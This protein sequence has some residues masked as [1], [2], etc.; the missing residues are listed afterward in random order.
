MTADLSSPDRTDD[1]PPVERLAD[2]AEGLVDSPADVE[3]LRRHLDGCAECRETVDALAEVQALL[4]EVETPPMPAD[5]ADRLDAAL[6]RAAAEAAE[7]ADAARAA[8]SGD[9]RTAA[10]RPQ[11]APAAAHRSA[12]QAPAARPATGPS[13]PPSRPAAATGPGRPRPRRRRIALLL[14]AAAALAGL[15]LGGALL[16]HPDDRSGVAVTAGAP[17]GT[18][19][20]ADQSAR[21]PHA[22]GGGTTYRADGLAAQ[23]QQLLAR[24]DSSA[25]GLR[26]TAPAKPESV[27]PAEGARPEPASPT[28]P[29]AP[30][31]CPAPAPGVPLATDRGSY[32][33]SPVD[34]L[35][36]PLPGRPGLV[37]VYLRAADCGPVLLHQSVPTR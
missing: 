25:P 26:P 36:Y 30:P 21:T 14:G 15:G 28:S 33:G 18:G 9:D 35:V 29:T 7:S 34:V 10:T 31:S 27:L 1:H 23:I 6:A 4:G 32:D 8:A 37:D 24:S 5:V 3:A 22:A 17:A 2:L 12:A 13:A 20:A 16:L 19:T 11:E